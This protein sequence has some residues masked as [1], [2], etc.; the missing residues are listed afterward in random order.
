FFLSLR[1]RDVYQSPVFKDFQLYRLITYGYTQTAIWHLAANALGL[2]YVG[3]YLEKKIGIIRFIFV[4]HIGL[5]I[6]GIAIMIFYPNS[7]N[8][9]ASPAIFACLGILVNWLIRKKDLLN[10]YKSQSGFYFLVYYFIFSNFLGMRTLLFHLFG[11][12]I[13]FLLGFVLKENDHISQYK[14]Q[15]FHTMCNSNSE[16]YLTQPSED[17][18]DKIMD[19]R[20]EFLNNNE[21]AYGT[22]RL[23]LMNDFEAW[24]SKVRKNEKKETVEAGR[25]PSYEY[26]AIRRA[27]EKLIG[28]IN[29]RYD[30]TE[31]MLMY[32]GHIGYCVRKSERQKGYAAEMLRLALIEAKKKGLTRVLL[33]VDN[34]KIASIAT[35][36]KNGAV[37]E[38][39][40]PYNNKITQRYWIEL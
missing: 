28:M 16:I 30:L 23:H 35:M 24:L 12:C 7:F 5:V 8:Y 36:K 25:P 37:L 2:W 10:E 6:A 34:D 15:E 26:M 17:F 22:E 13:G 40:V 19:F 39:E 11:F 3:L 14:N 1:P 20:T 27:D 32:L 38:N 21:V 29:V 9:G 33:T 4:Y 31:E 18:K